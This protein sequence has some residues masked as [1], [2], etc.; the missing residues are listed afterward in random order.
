[1]QSPSGTTMMLDPDVA[2]PSWTMKRAQE[3]IAK[4]KVAPDEKIVGIWVDHYR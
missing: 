1:M 3:E 2:P 4:F